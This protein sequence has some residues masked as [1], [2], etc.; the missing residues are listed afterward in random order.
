MRI[1]PKYLIILTGIPMFDVYLLSNSSVLGPSLPSKRSG[2]GVET[3]SVPK[4]L[5]CKHKELSLI[6]RVCVK[7]SSM[8]EYSY[9]PWKIET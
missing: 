8:V 1:L 6:C 3:G 2:S 9:N 4:V 5:P 7:V